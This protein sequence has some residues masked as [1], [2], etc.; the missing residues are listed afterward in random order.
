VF[1]GCWDLDSRPYDA[2]ANSFNQGNIFL[3]IRAAVYK[4]TNIDLNME[5]KEG[6]THMQ[7]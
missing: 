4:E 6:E 1:A 5:S 7:A 3:V 2:T